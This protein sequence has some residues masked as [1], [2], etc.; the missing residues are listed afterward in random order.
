[1]AQA[2]GRADRV[3]GSANAA[4]P[5][6][7]ASQAPM[8]LLVLDIGNTRLKWA[9]FDA[10][11][12]R[13]PER[14][15]GACLLEDIERDAARALAALPAPQAMFGCAVAGEGVRRRVE[16][17]LQR[18][19]PARPRWITSQREQCGLRNSYAQPWLL[20]SDRWAAMIG[21]RGRMLDAAR[22]EARPARGVVVVC[23]GTAVTINC[24]TGDG[25]FIGGSIMPGYGL[26]LRALEMGTAGLRVPDGEYVAFAQNTS[27]ALMVGGT[28]AIAG[29]IERAWRR[30]AD[31]EHAQRREPP[32]L[33]IAGGAS[34]KL[35]PALELPHQQAEHLVFEGLLRIAA[36]QSEG[37][38]GGN[39]AA[40][41]N[42]G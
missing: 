6:H 18:F 41:R 20:G 4:R 7:C 39:A 25:L 2:Q 30:L 9:R 21:G 27:D 22:D 33:I 24:V 15:F 8:S 40:Q 31:F 32:A 34:A 23:V 36:A 16:L 35:S 10:A 42:G 12:P 29:A 19:A 11:D 3:A 13:L 28:D 26:M 14:D 38:A 37:A 17:L 1:M 5:F